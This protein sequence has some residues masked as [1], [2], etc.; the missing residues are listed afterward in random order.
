MWLDR[1]QDP[2]N[3]DIGTFEAL[4]NTDGL[5]WHNKSISTRLW[6]PDKGFFTSGAFIGDYS[7]IA[8]NNAVVY[9]AWTDGRRNSINETGIG[10]T[11]V[12]TDVDIRHSRSLIANGSGG[13]AFGR[14]TSRLSA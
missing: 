14:P 1:R 7:G 9:P 12:F 4:S 10:E 6:D 2:A 8:A 3:H 5:T 11:D 13:A